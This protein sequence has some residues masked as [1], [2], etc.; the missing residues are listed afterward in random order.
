[1]TTPQVG[2]HRRND[3]RGAGTLEYLGAT[4]VATVLAIGLLVSPAGASIRDSFSEA[5]C[6]VIEREG[7][8]VGPGAG[9]TP[10][11][12]ATSGE[13]VALG[14]SYSSGEGAWDYE[15][16][17][18]FDDRDDLWP[19]N[20]DEEDH[21]R[22]HRSHN[23]YSQVLADHN[24]FE[25]GLTFV[26]CSGA[27]AGDLSHSNH[28]NTGE[29]PQLDALDE[30]T[31]LVTMTMGG[32]DIGFAD[33]VTDCILNGEG[34][35]GFIATCQ[36]KHDQ[37]IRDRLPE[38]EQE[39]IERYLA[40][41]EKAPNARVIIIGYPQL[42]PDNPSDDYHDLLFAED[43]VWMN[44]MAGLLNSM[45]ADAAAEAG[46]EFVDPTDAFHGHGIGSDDPWINDLDMGGPGLM[47]ADP[48]SFHPNA[49]GHAAIADL[50]QQ[51]LEHPHYR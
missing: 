22:C 17:T 18:D 39:L 37:R 30:D 33:V 2:R 42:F 45:L 21:N 28:S 11:E 46:V 7:C 50:I 23:A 29:D 24:D 47:I 43:Q 36:E 13:Y 38:L 31:S 12:Q 48:S 51:Q 25:G 34:G 10:L 40:I 14:D 27:V 1:M 44:E 3:E 8:A 35:V 41:K 5:I 19:F 26:A 4:I 32:N 49:A 15:E 20:D 9:G 16:G 6:S